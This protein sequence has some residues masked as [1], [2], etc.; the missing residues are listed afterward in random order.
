MKKMAKNFNWL[1]FAAGLSQKPVLRAAGLMSGTSADGIDAAII[2]FS[3]KKID[4]LAFYT[5]SYPGAVRKAIFELFD[6]KKATIGQ[7]SH[8]NFV[9]GEL[10]ANAVKKLCKKSGIDIKTI[11]L[12]G[13]HGQTIFHNPHGKRYGRKII[14]S[15]FQIAEPCVIAQRAG[16]LTVAD[17]RT[18][19]IAA[20][21]QGAPLVPYTDYILFSHKTKNRI[22]QNIGG[23]ANLTWLA[24]SGNRDDIIAFDTGPGNMIIDHIAELITKGRQ[25]YDKD[26][27]MAAKGS[28]NKKFLEGLM[29]NN[30]FKRHPPKTAGRE[31]FGIECADDIY[32]SGLR[33]EI[34]SFDLLATVTAFTAF[35]IADAYRRFIEKRID[36][37]IVCGGGSRNPVLMKML[38]EKLPKSRLLTMDELGIN[39]DAKEAVSF[40]ILAALTIKGICGNAP[41][42][43]GAEKPVILGKIIPPSL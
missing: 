2:D 21:G 41:S 11:D 32:K 34:S 17:F 37:V 14:R 16:I 8:L 40:A 23:I 6:T 28:V 13:S 35:S 19:D 22:I 9:L 18:A 43:T 26:G 33:E 3:A 12:I 4:V 27:R 25:K 30:Y 38:D 5:F 1:K 10:F 20:A 42:A 24:A 15:T 36:E 39:A 7:V 31:Q 29:R